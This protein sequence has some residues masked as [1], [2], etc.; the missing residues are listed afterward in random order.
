MLLF[1][2]VAYVWLTFLFKNSSNVS[3]W[4][5]ILHGNSGTVSADR[6]RPST[7]RTSGYHY[8]HTTLTLDMAMNACLLCLKFSEVLT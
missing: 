8:K 7:L 2:L 6:C 1:I 5:L 3:L 4:V